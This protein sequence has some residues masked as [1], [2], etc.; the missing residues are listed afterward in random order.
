MAKLSRR[1]YADVVRFY[2]SI[3]NR[4]GAK[5][6][7]KMRAAECLT[8]IY[9]KADA[10]SAHERAET[11]RERAEA[12][13]AKA[14]TESLAEAQRQQEGAAHAQQSSTD[15]REREQELKIRE[16]YAR[17]MKRPDDTST[18]E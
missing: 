10:A 13:R 12:R 5:D 7:L 3:I 18:T 15:D 6:E 17:V 11:R 4:D 9:E 16:M 2:K 1:R 8:A 14:L